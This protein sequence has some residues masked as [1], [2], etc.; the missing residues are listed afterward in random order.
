MF[1][2]SRFNRADYLTAT[3]I[4]VSEV[5]CPVELNDDT[6][7]FNVQVIKLMVNDTSI[8]IY[9]EENLTSLKEIIECKKRH[10]DPPP[11]I[12]Y[13]AATMMRLGGFEVKGAAITDITKEGA[14][15]GIL[16]EP[17]KANMNVLIP[18]EVPNSIG[19]ALIT[20]ADVYVKRKI[21]DAYLESSKLGKTKEKK[22]TETDFGIY[23]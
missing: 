1:K 7:L 17:P 19:V 13:I 11:C 10:I 23:V 18:A 2:G 21:Y 9:P 12:D 20:E 3:D 8:I 14:Y 15:G 6:S 4:S 22:K 16:T 5:I